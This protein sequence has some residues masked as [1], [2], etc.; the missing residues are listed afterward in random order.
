M[1]TLTTAAVSGIY[2]GP[3]TIK[4][5]GV[6][7]SPE[8]VI[9]GTFEVGTSDLD[10]SDIIHITPLPWEAKIH[11]ISIFTDDLDSN[12]TPALA[13]DVGLY[14]LDH[15][16]TFAV[17]DVDAYAS[18]VTTGQAANILGVNHAFE[19]R[20]INKMGNT[21]IQDAAI[22]GRPTDGYKAI[23]SATVTTASA[24]AAAG[25]VSYIVKYTL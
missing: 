10:A 14:S 17:I 20:D 9:K 1:S 6:F 3:P 11:E 18:A 16:N 15:T 7:G 24:T 13:Y 19:A 22:T 8:Y 12:G 25:T 21:V 2:A 5:R 4:S 23:L